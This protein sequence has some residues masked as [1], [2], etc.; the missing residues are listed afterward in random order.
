MARLKDPAPCPRIWRERLGCLR[1]RACDGG[2]RGGQ[3]Q[4]CAGATEHH[5]PS[6]AEPTT[7][8]SLSY[9]GC[10]L[11]GPRRVANTPWFPASIRTFGTVPRGG[12]R[13]LTLVPE[14]GQVVG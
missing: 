11:M 9:F 5:A 13:T 1:A 3:Q 14:Q 8:V 6:V 7:A 4:Q 10:R 2:R 12:S